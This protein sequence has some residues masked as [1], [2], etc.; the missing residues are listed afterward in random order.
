MPRPLVSVVTPF[1]NSAAYL[2]D[3]IRSVLA[4][5]YCEFEYI[6]VDNC[7]TDESGCIAEKYARLD[8]RIRF[9]RNEHHVPQVPNYNGALRHISE[10][11]EFCKIVQADDWIFER[12]LEEMVDLAT[13]YPD[14]GI[15]GAYTLNT[16]R[17][18]LDGLRFENTVIDG[19]EL[20]RRFIL[21]GLYVFGSPT[22]TLM[23]S[24]IVRSRPQFYEEHNP[25]EDFHVCVEIL[26]L[27]DFG[28][29]HQVLT[30][31]RRDN[32]SITS[33]QKGFNPILM[34]RLTSLR[35]YGRLFLTDAEYRACQRR[36]THAHYLLLGE[37]VWRRPNGRFWDYQREGL[38]VIDQRISWP[39]VGVYSLL[40]AAEYVLNPKRTLETALRRLR[41]E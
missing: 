36:L 17:V 25:V 16:D 13:Q 3:C 21:D 1:Y 23:R 5:T 14:V 12:C 11:S 37:G 4:Q 6:L 24:S 7:S 38:N 18:Y 20:C 34:A 8:P 15:V 41:Q 40:A 26:Q 9:L 22:A 33:S 39:R 28:F 30:Y 35:R 32:E 29:V 31:T 10:K 27:S 2:E 19:K